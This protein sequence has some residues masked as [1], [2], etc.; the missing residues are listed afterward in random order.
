M[1]IKDSTKGGNENKSSEEDYNS[2][3]VSKSSKFGKLVKKAEFYLKNPNELNQM[4]T[5][6]YNKATN[7]SGNKTVADMWGNLQTLF[8]MVRAHFNKEYT[9]LGTTKLIIGIGV[10]LYFLIPFDLIPDFLPVMGYI[11]DA[12]LLAWFIK[13]SVEE[14]KKFSKWESDNIP[15]ISPPY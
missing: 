10:I 11:D 14:I 1:K 4:L 5:E 8:R 15:T 13:N 6:A 9:G 7:E 2:N 12:S 3:W